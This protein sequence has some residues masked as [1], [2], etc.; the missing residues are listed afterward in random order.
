MKISARLVKPL[1]I[2]LITL[3]LSSCITQKQYEA[4]G[5]KVNELESLNDELKL[6][7]HNFE[8]DNKELESQISMLEKKLNKLSS[9]T[10]AFGNS[11]R[12]LN[13]QYDRMLNIQKELEGKYSSGLTQQERTNKALI[14]ELEVSRNDLLKYEDSLRKI[15]SDLASQRLDLEKSKNDLAE[16]ELRI[17]ELRELLERK[18]ALMNDL[19]LKI[20]KALYSLKGEGL[21][22][23]QKHGKIYVRMDASLLFP[24]GSV[25]MN[26][27]GKNAIISLAKSIEDQVDLQIIVEGH[28]DSDGVKAGGKFSDNWELSVLRATT[29]TKIMIENS[30]MDPKILTASGQSEYHPLDAD[31]KSKNRRIEIILS[32]NLDLLFSILEEGSGE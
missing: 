31:D 5:S 6:A 11:L 13:A 19:R 25:K 24:S 10:L 3:I 8:A 4:M 32:P 18:E 28:T 9:D 30:K 27:K 29:V 21:T 22:L 15:E 16:K 12:R 23:E 1:Y 17:Q 2:S 14:G 7:N 26:E 20:E